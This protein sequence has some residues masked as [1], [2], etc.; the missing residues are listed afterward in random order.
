M[1]YIYDDTVDDDEDDGAEFRAVHI[2]I[3]II[4]RKS[5]GKAGSIAVIKKSISR[6]TFFLCFFRRKVLGYDDYLKTTVIYCKKSFSSKI[7]AKP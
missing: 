6:R 5:I 3:C 2:L 4:E 7:Q 1:V